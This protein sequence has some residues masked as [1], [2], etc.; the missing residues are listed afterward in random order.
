MAKNFTVTYQLGSKMFKSKVLAENINDAQNKVKEK[1]N[2]LCVEESKE[3][4][5]NQC[6]DALGMMH[7]MVDLMAKAKKFKDGKD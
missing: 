4:S 7:E 2:F 3:D 6:M 1:I 5:F